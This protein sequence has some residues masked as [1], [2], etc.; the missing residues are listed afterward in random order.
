M[1]TQYNFKIEEDLK[2]ELEAIQKQDN[3]N[4]KEEFLQALLNSHKHYQAN[5]IDTDID[6]SKYETVSNQTKTVIHEAFKHILATLESNNTNTKQQALSLEKDKLSLIDE[7]KSFQEQLEHQQ[8]DHNQKL[9]NMDN[10]HKEQLKL[11]DEDIEKLKADNKDI[12]DSKDIL[13]TQLSEVQKI[14]EQV[15]SIT[16][17]NK[18]LREQ[19]SKED[20]QHKKELLEK[21]KDLQSQAKVFQELEKQNIRNEISL[22]NKSQEIKKLEEQLKAFKELERQNIVLS[23]KLEILEK[24]R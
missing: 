11:K 2:A 22:Q 5:Q 7:R 12:Q 19:L 4:N 21:E 24:E 14:A 16:E 8:A 17:A 20:K 3:I 18:E 9:L 15:Q 13:D 1:K 23:T 10:Q 6:L